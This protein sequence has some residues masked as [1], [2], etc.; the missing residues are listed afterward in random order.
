MRLR[1][2]RRHGRLALR[3]ALFASGREGSRGQSRRG[4]ESD[5][6]SRLGLFQLSGLV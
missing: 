1:R 2:R 3:A 4:G 6:G 5:G